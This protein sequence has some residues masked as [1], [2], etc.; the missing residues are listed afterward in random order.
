MENPGVWNAAYID[1]Q[2]SRWKESPG[3]V[4][5][6]WQAFFQ[7]FELGSAR[8]AG[9]APEAL[10]LQAKA[11]ALIQRYRDLGHL[12]SCLD[13]LSV[14]PTS[15][16][17]LDLEAF[18]LGREDLEKPVYAPGF[19][20]GESVPL[21]VA[22][23]ILRETYCHSVGVEYMHLQDPGEREWLRSRLEPARGRF[24]LSA[25]DRRWV[26]EWLCRAGRF[27]EFLQRRY[28]GQTRFSLEGAEALIPQLRDLMRVAARAGVRQAVLGMA[29]RGRLNVHVNLLGKSY[30][31]VFCQFEATY[32]PEAV[33][34]GGDVKYHSGY[35]GDVDTGAGPVHVVLPENPSH[36]EAVNPVVEGIARALQDRLG[37]EGPRR[38][39]PLLIHGDSAFP[40]QGI[41]A[42]TLNMARLA[43]YSTG[44]TLHVVLNNQIG[45]TTLPE[46]ARSTRYATDVAKMLMVPIFHVHGENP[47]A[48]LFA[49][50]LAF[51]YRMEFGKDAVIDLVCYR[52]HGHNE[53]DEPYFTQPTLYQR[54]RERPTVYRLFADEMVRDGIAREGDLE[55]VVGEIDGAMDRAYQTAHSQACVWVPPQPWDG[56]ESLDNRYTSDAV[57]TAYPAEALRDLCRA[58]ATAPEGFRVHPK[59]QKIVERR[60]E[61]VEQGRGIDWAGAEALAFGSLVSEGVPIRLSGEDSGRGTFS[62]R[63]A[64][65]YDAE[66]GRIHVPLDG[67]DG[68]RARFRVHDSPLSEAAVLG[69]EYGYSAVDPNTLVLWEAQYGDFADGAQVITDQFVA[70]GEAKWQRHTGVV[71]LLPHGYEG[72]GPDHSTA[73]P[74]RFLQLCAED[75]MAVC[76]P[77]TPAQYFHLLRR[78]VRAPWRKPLVVLTP[79]SLLRHPEAVS[80]LEDLAAGLFRL[81]LDDPEAPKPSAV[82][83]VLLCTGK[84]YYAL[85][86]ARRKGGVSGTA[87]VRLEQLHPF[88]AAELEALRK[89]YGK[90]RDWVWVQEEPRNMGAWTFAAPRLAEVLG[91]EAAYVGRPEAASPA[92]GFP[93][94][95]RSE[96]EQLLREALPAREK[97]ARKRPGK[98]GAREKRRGG[99]A[100]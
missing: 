60:V 73:R 87:L 39:L 54:I 79:K 24:D 23:D 100:A 77:T 57:D 37:E 80:P 6:E 55:A 20:E 47:A 29:H 70:S 68:G 3:A 45:Y 40:G 52:R 27:E 89:R 33:P 67:L 99:R 31:E 81:V 10:A 51:A 95:H 36:L 86:E 98:G 74:E 83:R 75:N 82:R 42:E 53:G 71:L 65:W 72:Q 15:H 14:C 18:G 85:A 38:V 28:L 78:Q 44:G 91:R 61:A 64:V 1:E 84:V 56:W 35:V 4:S 13:P 22:V 49:T 93:F 32:D 63:H 11:E 46:N 88:P 59:L 16:P 58:L 8:P 21:G 25:D 97:A 7:G 30:E 66:D 90:A 5:A 17:L 19:G 43:G 69:F 62:Q 92:T 48:V 12:M 26:L 50:R 41:V 96:E 9:L 34:G 76:Q 94:L 2:Y